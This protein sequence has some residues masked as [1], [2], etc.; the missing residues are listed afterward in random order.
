MYSNQYYINGQVVYID[1]AWAKFTTYWQNQGYGSS[2]IEDMW[3]R[4]QVSEEARDS[5]L[6]G[7]LNCLEIIQG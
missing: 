3:Q 7:K 5:F 4:C 6:V 1:R 2:T